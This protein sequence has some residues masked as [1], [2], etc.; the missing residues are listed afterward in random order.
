[1]N[2]QDSVFDICQTMLAH[3]PKA[4]YQRLNPALRDTLANCISADLPFKPDTF[5]RVYNELRGGWWFGD[6]GGSSV[7]E[8]FY[9]TAVGANHASACQSFDN[10][11]KRPGVLWEED[12]K[13]PV[14]LCVGSQFTWLGHFVTVTS[15]RKDSLVACT[16][17]QCVDYPC[18]IQIGSQI[19]YGANAHVITAAKRDGKATILRVIKSRQDDGRD[20]ERR[21]TITYAQIAEYRKTAKARLNE[22]LEAVEKCN[23]DSDGERSNLTKLVSAQ[24]FRHWELEQVNTAFAR[25]KDWIANQSRIDDWR[26]NVNGAWLDV[27]GIFLRVNGDLVE[28]S[29]GNCVSVAAV[30]RVLPIVLDNRHGAALHLPVDGYTIKSTSAIGVKIGCTMVPWTEVDYVEKII[31]ATA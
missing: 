28:C 17:K 2:K 7:G 15:M 5:L 6:C 3:S 16:Y 27:N 24:H 18:G 8:H 10:F 26:K 21:F 20:I 23:L 12:A 14:R 31:Q 25:R 29:N 13:T 30:R 9:T 4:S 19:G 1:M 11:A 22:V